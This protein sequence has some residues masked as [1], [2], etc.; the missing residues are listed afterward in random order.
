M[1]TD[2]ITK[3]TKNPRLIRETH[4]PTGEKFNFLAAIALALRKTIL[5]I[6]R[7]V[8]ARL[9]RNVALLFT[10]S[11]NCLVHFARATVISTLK[12]HVILL[13]GLCASLLRRIVKIFIQL[14]LS[15]LL[16]KKGFFFPA[17]LPLSLFP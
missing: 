9:E 11:A 8:F 17:K 16:A 6:H 12:S 7:T 14:Y 10:I 2:H 13:F 1:P 15:R 4:G 3:S 5:A